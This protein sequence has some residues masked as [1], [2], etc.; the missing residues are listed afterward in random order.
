MKNQ[1]SPKLLILTGTGR[2]GTTYMVGLLRRVYGFGLSA[3]AKDLLKLNE[4]INKLDPLNEENFA[5][6]VDVVSDSRVLRHAISKGFISRVDKSR[7]IDFVTERSAQGILF[8]MLRY[9]AVIRGANP[10]LPAFK[11]PGALRQLRQLRTLFPNALVINMIRRGE[12]VAGSTLKFN[13]GATNQVAGVLDWN[14][15]L[16]KAMNEMKLFPEGHVLNLRLED[17]HE[18][19]DKFVFK[20]AHFVE[21]NY[22][23]SRKELLKQDLEQSLGSVKSYPVG[24]FEGLM[25]KKLAQNL[26]YRLGYSVTPLPLWQECAYRVIALPFLLMDRSIRSFRVLSGKFKSQ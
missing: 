2:S 20:I 13:W 24:G 11:D 18:D 26:N 19:L 7:I 9:V 25:I 10:N 5:T 23:E 17:A 21:Q 22:G 4:D 14:N 3:E 12:D 15:T 8:A 1:N 16:S 6:A